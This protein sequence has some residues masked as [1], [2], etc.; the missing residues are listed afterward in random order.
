M[1]LS[2]PTTSGSP[3][4]ASTWRIR[5][6]CLPTGLNGIRLTVRL[7]YAFARVV[8]LHQPTTAMDLGDR[9]GTLRFLIHDGDPVSHHH[10]R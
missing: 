6:V 5:L 9:L 3:H 10:V 2:V 1:P 8:D 7:R 4:A